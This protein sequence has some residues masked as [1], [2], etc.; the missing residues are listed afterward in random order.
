MHKLLFLIPVFPIVLAV[1]LRFAPIQGPRKAFQSLWKLINLA[2]Y[3]VGL[4]VL[5]V[6]AGDL[7]LP[8]TILASYFLMFGGF[9]LIPFALAVILGVLFLTHHIV[10]DHVGIKLNS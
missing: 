6:L 2:P 1:A 8:L 10:M 5:V 7:L 9:V 3:L 4:L